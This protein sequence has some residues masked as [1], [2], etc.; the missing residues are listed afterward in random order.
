[1][2]HHII[3]PACSDRPGDDHINICPAFWN[4]HV[5]QRVY[6][7]AVPTQPTNEAVDV[8]YRGYGYILLHELLHSQNGSLDIQDTVKDEFGKTST[9]RGYGHYCVLKYA[10][11]NPDNARG[12]ADTYALFALAAYYG[13]DKYQTNPDLFNT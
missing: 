4:W 13:I 1:M 10:Q 12:N 11:K 5:K 6:E 3:V 9:C 8:K 2:V 7:L